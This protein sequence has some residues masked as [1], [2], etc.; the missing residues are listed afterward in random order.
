MCYVQHAYAH[1]ITLWIQ[2]RAQGMN[3]IISRTAALVQRQMGSTT[4]HFHIQ[5]DPFTFQLT[6]K[7]DKSWDGRWHLSWNLDTIVRNWLLKSACFPPLNEWSMQNEKAITH[8]QYKL[9]FTLNSNQTKTAHW[10]TMCVTKSQFS[11]IWVCVF[12]SS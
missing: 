8:L 9:T 12:P 5:L 1:V 3:L 11:E 6:N 7:A 10:F 4:S 2:G